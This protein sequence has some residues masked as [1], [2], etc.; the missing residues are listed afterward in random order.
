MAN[1]IKQAILS[2]I[3]IKI[4]SLFFGLSLWLL[5]SQNYPG[6]ISLNI[7]L[8]FYSTKAVSIDA[9]EAIKVKLAGRRIAL[10]K[11]DHNKLAVHVDTDKM[12]LGKNNLELS[13]DKL[14]LPKAIKMLKYSPTTIDIKPK[15][16][17]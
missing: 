17:A 8:C 14:F 7:P 13:S 6:E 5:I 15:E 2:N 11:L 9:P 3:T 10:R 4:A 12:P 16:M 1:K